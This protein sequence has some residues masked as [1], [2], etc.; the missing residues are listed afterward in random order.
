MNPLLILEKLN[1]PLITFVGFVFV[2]IIGYIDYLTGYEY[3]FSVFY[4]LPISFVA[5]TSNQGFGYAASIISAIVWIVADVASGQYYSDPRIPI[6]NTLIRLAFF[7]IITFLIS[8]LKSTMQ[9]VKELSLTDHLTTASNSRH[10]F[11][12]AQLE[13]NRFQRY[14]RA[15]TIAYIDVDNF[16]TVNDKFGHAEGDLVLQ[17]VVNFLRK[18]VRKSDIVARLGGDEFA[19]LFP[20]TNQESAQKIFSNIQ[21]TLLD[22]MQKHKWAVTFSIGVLTCEVAPHTTDEL[23]KM[24]DELMYSVKSSS[25]NSVKYSVYKG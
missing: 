22:E 15:F 10:F 1:K 24:A 16:K 9:Q 3:A 18:T 7:I 5:W 2:G 19:L 11:D 21:C 20:E 13:T 14:Q 23:I 25:K 4:V 8:S 17:T 6:W 12:V